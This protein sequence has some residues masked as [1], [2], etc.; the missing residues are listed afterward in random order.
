MSRREHPIKISHILTKF[1]LVDQLEVADESELSVPSYVIN[2]GWA[3][4][5][6]L[7][8]LVRMRETTPAFV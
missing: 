8:F 2:R 1:R 5:G 6:T 3:T 4:P 7:G